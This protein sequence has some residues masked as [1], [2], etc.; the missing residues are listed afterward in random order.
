MIGLDPG[1]RVVAAVNSVARPSVGLRD[2][3]PRSICW[4]ARYDVAF[5]PSPR[6]GCPV[7]VSG[8]GVC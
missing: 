8:D 2:G 1:S 3:S 5:S 6:W 7:G 4:F